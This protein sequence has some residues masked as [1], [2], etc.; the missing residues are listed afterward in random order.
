MAVYGLGCHPQNII[1]T[2]AKLWVTDRSINCH[3]ARHVFVI[4][5][6]KPKMS[7]DKIWKKALY[8]LGP[9]YILLYEPAR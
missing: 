7:S 9:V 8:G 3:L 4:V 1:W 5:Y 2:E 6:L